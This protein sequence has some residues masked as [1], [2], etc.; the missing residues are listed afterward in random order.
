MAAASISA[1]ADR[2]IAAGVTLAPHRC[3]DRLE[4]AAPIRSGGA[5]VGALV[6]RWTIGTPHDLG[7][8]A[9]LMTTVAA[10]IAPFVSAATARARRLSV[11]AMADLLGTSAAMAEVRRGV[12][13]AAPAP[14]AVLD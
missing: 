9:S 10:A 6:A 5:V 11:P 13:R 7:S 1:I 12:E 3:G 2:A 14:F 8:A 4:A